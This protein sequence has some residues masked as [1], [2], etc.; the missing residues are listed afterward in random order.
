VDILSTRCKTTFAAGFH[1]SIYLNSLPNLQGLG[2]FNAF[3]SIMFVDDGVW[4]SWLIF[5]WRISWDNELFYY[6][7]A[8][9][10]FFFLFLW[11]K[12]S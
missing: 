3:Q 4:Q 2:G 9:I 5:D 7:C 1:F 10:G 11:R 6:T 8:F 12:A